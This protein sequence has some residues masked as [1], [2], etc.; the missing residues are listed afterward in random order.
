[1]TPNAGIVALLVDMLMAAA[2]RRPESSIS[3]VMAHRRVDV[4]MPKW[5]GLE[6][7]SV[8]GRQSRSS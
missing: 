4:E 8:I 5:P 6:T 1:V 2:P 3:A 7:F